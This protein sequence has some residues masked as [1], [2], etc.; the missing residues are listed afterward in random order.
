M[1]A[2]SEAIMNAKALEGVKILDF[3]W[4]A[5]GPLT[6][7]EFAKYGAFD[8]KVESSK[9][10]DGVRA[11]PPY[12]K[13]KA[14]L[15]RS[16]SFANDNANKYSIAINTKTEGGKE[17][18]YELVKWADIICEN[19]RPGAMDRM[20]FGYEELKKINP[21]IIMFR[22]SMNGQTGPESKLA[23]T[24]TELQGYTGFTYLTGFPDQDPSQPWCAYTDLIVP[25]VGVG[26]LAAALDYKRKT[27]KG[28]M[29]DLSQLEVSMHFLAPGFLDFFAN[30]HEMQRNGN[31]CDYAAPHGVYRC[32]G[33]DRWVTIACWN[34]EDWA[35]CV[36]V[37]GD[38]E[39]AADP[40]FATL[41]GRKANEDEL[42]AN[43]EAWTVTQLCEEVMY[44]MQYAGVEAAYVET[45]KDLL[46]NDPQMV[47]RGYLTEMVIDPDDGET[48]HHQGLAFQMNKTPYETSF[49]APQIGEHTSM[50]VSDILHMD[51]ERFVE[52]FAQGVFE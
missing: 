12:L 1:N 38:P 44:N 6:T 3:T 5:A 33:D 51:D 42:N 31:K 18:V 47:T 22:S 20:G 43:I 36:K 17:V 16:L 49:L 35:N 29:I 19:M 41:A 24:G 9:K 14:G 7:I 23:A 32:K 2:V 46:E 13:G 52:L 28:Q 39:W 21:G 8:L 15:G 26:M 25:S 30:G 45:A 40:K 27:G 34:D 37:I 11:T 4:I 48:M 50:V 10:P